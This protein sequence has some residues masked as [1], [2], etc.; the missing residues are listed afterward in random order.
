MSHSSIVTGLYIEQ[1]NTSSNLLQL[2]M[3]TCQVDWPTFIPYIGELTL[4][5]CYSSCRCDKGTNITVASFNIVQ[6]IPTLD[7]GL[8]VHSVVHTAQ[9]T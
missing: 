8:P 1:C 2:L 7:N 3:K 9:A 5:T 4:S 6:E